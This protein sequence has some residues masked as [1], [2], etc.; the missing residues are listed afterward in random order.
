MAKLWTSVDK[1][2]EKVLDQYAAAYVAKESMGLF[3]DWQTYEK[4]TNGEQNPSTGEDDPASV[5][6][7]IFPNIASQVSDIVDDPYDILAIGEEV[8]DDAY[9]NDVQHVMRWLW[10]MNKMLFKLDKAA[11]RFLKFGTSVFKV[12]YNPKFDRS[13]NGD[14]VYA[15]VSPVNFFP[16]PKVKEVYDFQSGDYAQHAYYMSID[17]IKRDPVYGPRAK[18]LQPQ[19]NGSYNL[20][21]FNDEG[22]E[23]SLEWGRNKALML[24][25]W[26]QRKDGKRRILT[27]NEIVLYDSDEDPAMKDEAFYKD[28]PFPFV[29]GICYPVEGRFWGMGDVQ[30]LMASQDLINDLD[31]QIRMNA[32]LMGNL[33][34]VVGIATGINLDKWTNKAGLKIP[35]K[36]PGAWKTVEP[37]DMPA[38]VLNRRAEAFQEAEL[39]SG[40]P[41]VV[42]GRQFGGLRNASAIL[43]LQEAGSK[44]A[45]HKKLFMEE[46]LSELNRVAL[47]FVKE[48][49]TEEQ[50]FRIIGRE[51]DYS[52]PPTYSWFKGS[53]LKKIPV[54]RPGADGA[55]ESSG[56]T[57]DARLDIRVMMGSGMPSN[58]AFLLQTLID[59][60]G[61]EVV[62]AEEVRYALSRF[63][64]FPIDPMTLMG[65]NFNGQLTPRPQAPAGALD[66]SQIPP[67]MLQYLISMLGG[68]GG[69]GGAG[70]ISPAAQTGMAQMGIP[71]L[72]GGP[73]A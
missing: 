21:F 42:E 53:S 27:A 31:D 59:L 65:N 62:T 15:P 30:L 19:T 3:K 24:E 36:D 33:Q 34:I 13:R 67:D 11:W 70:G 29:P 55:W 61:A 49:Y 72:R 2:V 37:K 40:R 32:R 26:Q 4:Y 25:T 44:R 47:W 54:L 28:G 50:A 7:I 9:A 35:A 64:N 38:Y 5:T 22:K 6:N 71:G 39:I 41:D 63:I 52:A 46:M 16:D 68:Q 17:A 23:E 56:S 18:G 1:R 43:A 12:S 69:G 58:K 10:Y 14:I 48:F 73:G 57:K 8:S 60:R 66:P 51:M 45:R 20:K